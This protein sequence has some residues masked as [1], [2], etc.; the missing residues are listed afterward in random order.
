L[1][2]RRLKCLLWLYPPFYSDCYLALNLVFHEFYWLASVLLIDL[3][4]YSVNELLLKPA[5]LLT[6][7]QQ[8]ILFNLSLIV[9]CGVWSAAGFVFFVPGD[10]TAN[11]IMVVL[12]ITVVGSGAYSCMNNFVSLSSYYYWNM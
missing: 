11:G 8:F 2:N 1:K 10:D 6:D 9:S 4:R 12:M 3:I 5:N 7:Q